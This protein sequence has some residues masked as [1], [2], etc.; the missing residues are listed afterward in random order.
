MRTPI[1]NRSRRLGRSGVTL[2]E[3][4]TVVTI[5]GLLMALLFPALG[6]ARAASRRAACQSNL[7]QFAVGMMAHADRH[8]TYCSGAF[9]WNRDGPVTEVGWVADLVNTGTLVGQMLCP[10]SPHE[11]SAAYFDLLDGDAAA[12]DPCIDHLGSPVVTAPD[13]S[14][15][16]NPCRQII[17]TPLGPGTEARRSLVETA[18]YKKGFNTNYTASWFLVRSGLRLSTDGNLMDNNPVGVCEVSLKSL[19]STVGPLQQARVDTGAASS[20]IIPL[21]GDGAPVGIVSTPVGSV[22]PGTF[23]VKSFTNGPVLDVTMDFPTFAPGTPKEGAAGWWAIW[24]NATLQDYRGFSPVHQGG[25][26]VLF[27]DGSVRC[28]WEGN[29]KRDGLLNNGFS[30]G[31]TTGFMSDEVEVTEEDIFSMWSLRAIRP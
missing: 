13:G 10:A 6:A 1:R 7:K 31:A 16:V 9:D 23:F 12:F 8:G 22:K 3:L 2:V 25:C 27:A 18:I 5:I 4:L 30:A 29:G 24:N 11:L 20:S 14:P 15:I 21:L 26:N 17:E 19:A 28:L